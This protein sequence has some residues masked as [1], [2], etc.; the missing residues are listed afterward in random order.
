LKRVI[1]RR[2]AKIPY[3]GEVVCSEF[4]CGEPLMDKI[5]F[6]VDKIG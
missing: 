1:T 6:G 2:K 5:G 3:Y 4:G